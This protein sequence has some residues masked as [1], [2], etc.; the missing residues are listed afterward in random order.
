MKNKKWLFCFLLLVVFILV[1]LAAGQFTKKQNN[2]TDDLGNDL[3]QA[4]E[5]TKGALRNIADKINTA[6]Y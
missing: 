3:S 5:R 1:V 2:A 6:I 4:L